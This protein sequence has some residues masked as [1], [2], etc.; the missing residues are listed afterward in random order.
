MSVKEQEQKQEQKER[1]KLVRKELAV[2]FLLRFK[3]TA[4]AF[5]H[6]A[7]GERV[8]IDQSL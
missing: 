6:F 1:E 3:E 5:D 2:N 7:L 4:H 8:R